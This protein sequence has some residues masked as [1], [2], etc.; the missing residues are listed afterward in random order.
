MR[1]AL[2]QRNPSNEMERIHRDMDSFFDSF[3]SMKPST[4]FDA[5]WVPSVDV[6][7]EN[8]EIRV[9][10]EMPGLEEKDINVTIE[11]GIL[12]ISGEKK[13]EKKEEDKERNYILS[14]RSFGSFKRQIRLP[15]DVKSGDVKA[16]FRNGVLEI[17]LPRDEK[18]QPKKIQIQVK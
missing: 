16:K 17:T 10:A 4:L 13:E 14:E 3:F 11:N 15:D 5:D 2:T 18:A 6:T 1:W 7:E 8:G 9:K 12:S